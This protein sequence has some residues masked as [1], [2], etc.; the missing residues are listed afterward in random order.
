MNLPVPPLPIPAS[1]GLFSQRLDVSPLLGKEFS[2]PFQHIPY[3]VKDSNG[4]LVDS[5]MLDESG[6]TRRTFT[7]Q[8]TKLTYHIGNDP[9]RLFLDAKH[10]EADD[11]STE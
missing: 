7:E 9:W 4:R 2:I 3:V 1:V 6:N 10:A 11:E 5:G 8:P